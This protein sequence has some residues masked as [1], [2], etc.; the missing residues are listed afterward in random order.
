M[1][2]RLDETVVGAGGRIYLAKDSRVRAE[3]MPAM[4]PR[5]EQWRSVKARVDPKTRFQSDLGRRLG[6]C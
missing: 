6:L 5:L 4:Y 3:L 2:D 1:L